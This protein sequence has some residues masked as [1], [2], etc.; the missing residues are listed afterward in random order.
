MY[1][2][3]KAEKKTW[4]MAR[5]IS[6]R[7]ERGEWKK[8]PSVSADRMGCSRCLFLEPKVNACKT[9]DGQTDEQKGQSKREKS[10][11]KEGSVSVYMHE[12]SINGSRY[13][14]RGTYL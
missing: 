6:T 4:R 10:G 9:I 14:R 11:W 2:D 7:E 5:E 3:V 12:T 13:T 8:A 1:V